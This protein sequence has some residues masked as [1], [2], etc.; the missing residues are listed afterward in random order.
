MAYATTRLVNPAPGQR[1]LSAEQREAFLTKLE[2]TSPTKNPSGRTKNMARRTPP[3]NAKGQFVKRGGTK[4]TRR[5]RG[6]ARKH[7]MIRRRSNPG[8]I[9]NMS[10]G[11]VKV[12]PAAY[13]AVGIVAGTYFGGAATNL[14]SQYLVGRLPANAQG[15]G[16]AAVGI[17]TIMLGRY[18]KRKPMGKKL[19]VDYAAIGLSVPMFIEAMSQLRLPGFGPRVEAPAPAPAAETTAGTIRPRSLPGSMGGSLRSSLMPGTM[20]GS[21]RS[22]TGP[23]MGR[24]YMRMLR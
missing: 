19:P 6:T 3:R 7:A 18:L 16:W 11:G 13:D 20:G 1:T 24:T 15:I 5:Q 23:T 4:S 8:G 14:A 21:L 9:K 2:G 10:V 17:G 22:G 12:Y